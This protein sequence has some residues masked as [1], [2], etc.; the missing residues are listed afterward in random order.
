MICKQHPLRI[1]STSSVCN[2]LK[3]TAY[4]FTIRKT[5]VRNCGDHF[6]AHKNRSANRT[7]RS[8]GKTIIAACFYGF[9][10]HYCMTVGTGI[11]TYPCKISIVVPHDI[12]GPRIAVAGIIHC[13]CYSIEC[14]AIDADNYRCISKE[15]NACQATAFSERIFA[16]AGH[17]IRNRNARQAATFSERIIANTA[18]TRWNRDARQATAFKE[19]IIA[20]TAHTRW[21]RDA[22]QAAASV[23]HII[24]NAGYTRWNR[25]AHQA[26]T[27]S[28]RIIA[29]VGHAIRNRD[30]RQIAA[31]IERITTNAGHAL[32]DR[33]A[34]Q[35]ATSSERICR[36]AFCPAKLKIVSAADRTCRFKATAFSE[37]IFANAGH[38]IRNRDAR[39][40][41]T[42][43]ERR[44]AN[45]GHTRWNRDARKA[46][47]SSERICRNA[48]FPSKLVIISAADRTCRFKATASVEHIIANAGHALR[49][50]DARQ[51]AASIERRT[52]NAG[53]TVRDR[54]ARQAAAS[55]ECSLANAGHSIRYLILDMGQGF[56]DLGIR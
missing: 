44:I 10:N 46:A 16:N 34:R 39:K 4:T 28:E 11:K 53:H 3:A 31:S 24:A 15:L 5:M 48:F 18:H 30:T 8:F 47:T 6:L 27:F 9:V 43:I 19:C 56:A 2:T 50:R 32:R 52:A 1:S 12:S 42:F 17:A 29:N 14:T 55:V 25:D 36:N 23:E 38:A 51:A 41:A 33:D 54:D 7:M 49:D 26:A 45:T 40:A 22:R 37:R 35:A 13:G 20:N 21:N